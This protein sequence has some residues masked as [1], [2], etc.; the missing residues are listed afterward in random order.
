VV[1]APHIL[2]GSDVFLIVANENPATEQCLR[3]YAPSRVPYAHGETG[4]RAV[5]L[6]LSRA[7]AQN[8]GQ[9]ISTLGQSTFGIAVL[10]K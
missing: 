9:R 7:V 10:N 4:A 6:Q 2:G 3:L 8:L 5:S 1:V